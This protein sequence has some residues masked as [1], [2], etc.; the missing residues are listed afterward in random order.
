M[1]LTNKYISRLVVFVTLTVVI[2]ILGFPQPITGPLVNM[3]LILTTLILGPVAGVI[4]GILTPLIAVFRGQLP[5]PL[6]P[7]VPFIMFG[8]SI[9]VLLFAAIDQRLKKLSP[10][11]RLLASPGSWLAL[12][13]GAFAKFI[14][15]YSAVRILL[16][17]LI[18]T[19]IPPTV[20]AL[21]ST[22]QF[23]TAMTG[24]IFAFLL[25]NILQQRYHLN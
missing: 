9:F 11:R 21:M 19:S 3:M 6:M 7:M 4:L 24:G 14:W 12:F 18:G 22:P 25:F 15:L 20:L 16:P 5:P 1:H 10:S 23:F 8:N 17:R 2:E 13:A